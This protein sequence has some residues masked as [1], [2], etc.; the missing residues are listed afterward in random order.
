MSAIWGH[1]VGVMIVI[2]MSTFIGIWIWAWRDRHRAV[3]QRM[4]DL[5]MQDPV[6][7]AWRPETEQ[8]DES[9]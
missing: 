3:F 1:A 9:R 5:P 8:G 4:A 7:A 6:E 2:L